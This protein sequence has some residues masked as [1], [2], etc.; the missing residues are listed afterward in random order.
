[1]LLILLLLVSIWWLMRKRRVGRPDK[2]GPTVRNTSKKSAYHAVSIRF[3][4]NACPA[5]KAMT[6][7]RFLATAA[8][9]L[10][11]PDCGSAA[12]KCYFAHHED[13]R[14]GS[15]R[16]SP[17]SPARSS[18]GTGTQQREQREGGDRRSGSG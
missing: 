14:S 15:D 9:K 4:S 10:P 18:G 17:F 2:A 6:G 3:P 12:C 8:P 16:R 13:R 1:M 5:A 7:R 11:L